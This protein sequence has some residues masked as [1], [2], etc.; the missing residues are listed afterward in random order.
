MLQRFHHSPVSPP[1]PPLLLPSLLP[2]LPPSL[3]QSLL[4]HTGG[5]P[6]ALSGM[7]VTKGEDPSAEQA[8]IL[9]AAPEVESQT[10]TAGRARKRSARC[11]VIPV[12][13][14]SS[15]AAVTLTD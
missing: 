8:A 14:G 13:R 9:F 11:K 4:Q 5:G 10:R 7:E 2:S 15:P 12:V 6:E 3:P 1:I